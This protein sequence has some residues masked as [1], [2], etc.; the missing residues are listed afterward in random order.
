[1]LL[2][3]GRHADV[4][5]RHP[6]GDP[7]ADPAAGALLI[8][9]EVLTGFGRTGPLFA[10]EQRRRRPRPALPL[11]GT[12]RRVP[13]ARG[14][15]GDRAAVFD[16]FRAPIAGGPSFTATRSRPTRS[17]A[18]RPARSLALLDDA[19]AR[20][21]TAMRC[22]RTAEASSRVEG[23]PARGPPAGAGNGGGV[24]PGGLRGLS[25]PDRARLARPR[26]KPGVLLRP[27]GNV[28]YLL[29]PYCVTSEEIDGV[30]QL[31]AR[32]L[33]GV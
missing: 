1:M 16:A 20:R 19:C 10:C 15:G 5:R 24:R 22:G 11:Q 23:H 30:Y 26:W 31:L 14:H 13:P 4:G 6:P 8:A 9:D 3:G 17:P 27:L 25:R 33:A 28:V 18:R 21:R 12:D 32:L 2:G 29:P 7:R